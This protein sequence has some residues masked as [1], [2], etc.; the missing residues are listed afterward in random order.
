MAAS[1]SGKHVGCAEQVL[2]EKTMK[3]LCFSLVCHEKVMVFGRFSSLGGRVITPARSPGPW[4]S[5]MMF[6]K[7]LKILK[8]LNRKIYLGIFENMSK[9]CHKPRYVVIIG[10]H[11]EIEL[12]RK[13][14]STVSKSQIREKNVLKF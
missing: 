11:R 14:A 4:T 5:F 2:T 10:N 13:I 7:V 8:F 9:F 3:K 6:L 1:A 12:K